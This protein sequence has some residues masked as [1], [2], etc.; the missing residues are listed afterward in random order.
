VSVED[1]R[2]GDKAHA[3]HE[4]S[5]MNHREPTTD[6]DLEKLQDESFDFLYE[7]NSANGLVIDKTAPDGPASIAATTKTQ[8][9][10][11]NKCLFISSVLASDGLRGCFVGFRV[12][13]GAVRVLGRAVQGVEPE[14]HVSGHI[15][16]IVLDARGNHH[17]VSVTERVSFS[18]Q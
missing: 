15:E 14:R 11:T 3:D 16:H 6:A 4:G 10:S 9:S 1:I 13:D 17:R 12:L 2:I 18:V 8:A 5:E 7:T